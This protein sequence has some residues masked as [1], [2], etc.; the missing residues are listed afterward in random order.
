MEKMWK[1]VCFTYVRLLTQFVAQKTNCD[2]A[3]AKDQT[4]TAQ[5][6]ILNTVATIK[7]DNA[8]DNYDESAITLQLIRILQKPHPRT[9]KKTNLA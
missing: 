5:K 6:T 4:T 2:K 3:Q 8:P 1:N 7:Q 9:V